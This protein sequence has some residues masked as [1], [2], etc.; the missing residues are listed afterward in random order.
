MFREAGQRD[1]IEYDRSLRCSSEDQDQQPSYV[2]HVTHVI[3]E[4]RHLPQPY[5]VLALQGWVVILVILSHYDLKIVELFRSKRYG[6]CGIM[7]IG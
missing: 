2:N 7:A 6:R 1:S 5:R 3:I 4:S